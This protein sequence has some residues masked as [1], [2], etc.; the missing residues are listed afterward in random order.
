MASGELITHRRREGAV[1]LEV[2]GAARVADLGVEM[3]AA[4][5]EAIAQAE[6]ALGGI[7]VVHIAPL[8]DRLRVVVAHVTTSPRATFGGWDSP[9]IDPIERACRRASSI[10]MLSAFVMQS[11]VTRIT[12]MILT[13]LARG[14]HVRVLAGDYL[15]R[16]HPGALHALLD[17]A[18]SA[19]ADD[20]SASA[21][22]SGGSLEVR[23]MEM[24]SLGAIPSFHPKAWIIHGDKNSGEDAQAWVGSSNLSQAALTAGVE[25]NLRLSRHEDPEGFS[26]ITAQ[27]EALWGRAARVDRAWIMAYA[28][29]FEQNQ[30]IPPP[31]E[32]VTARP[33]PR[34]VQR[35]ALEALARHRTN[36]HD[37]ALVVLATGLGKTY[38]AAF[39]VEAFE[40]AMGR[41]ARILFVAHR[42]EL[43]RQ[44]ARTFRHIF[45]NRAVGFVTG[46]VQE[47][48]AQM[49]FASV[50]SLR[51][52]D[53]LEAIG[54]IDYLIIDEAHHARASTYMRLLEVVDTKFVLGLTATPERGD[55]QEILSLFGGEPVFEA[56]L[57]EGI[58]QG[59]LVPFEYFG[60][61]DTVDYAPIPWRSGKFSDEE[62][63]EAVAT[64][65][66][67]ERLL[68]AW[69]EHEGTRTLV[70]C[71][72]IGHADFVTAWL[73][74][75]G[76]RAA[77]VH[78][79][80]KSASR[81]HAIEQ[82][83]R[84]E[85]DALCTVD[86]F[87]EGVDIPALDR[88]VMLR[89]TGSRVIFL[90]QLGRG[91]RTAAGK[92]SLCVIDFVG[93]HTI[94]K[95]RLLLLTGWLRGTPTRL[96]ELED[97]AALSAT[98]PDGC[99]IDVELEAI[100]LLTHLVPN[101]AESALLSA[102]RRWRDAY[103]ARPTALDLEANGIN[104]YT[105][106]D[107]WGGWFQLVHEEGD[108]L[109]AQQEVLV[110]SSYW[111]EAL[112]AQGSRALPFLET[113]RRLIDALPED[114]DPVASLD[115]VDDEVIAEI[116]KR[117]S[118]LQIEARGLSFATVARGAR[119]VWK[120]MSLELLD[121]MIYRRRRLGHELSGGGSGFEAR[122]ISASGKAILTF[123][124][125]KVE[126]IPEGETPVAI[127]GEGLW[128]FRFV[129]MAVNVAAPHGS[130]SNQLDGLLRR[131]FGASAG[132][133]GTAFRVRFSRNESGWSAGPVS[134][135]SHLDED[136]RAAFEPGATLSG[137]EIASALGLGKDHITE[138]GELAVS[139]AWSVAFVAASDALARYDLLRGALETERAHV[140][141][142][143]EDG[144]GWVYHGVG[145][146][147]EDAGAWRIDDVDASTYARF[148]DKPSKSRTLPEY[149]KQ[150]AK[151][152][153]EALLA[154]VGEGGS[155]NAR[156]KTCRVVT[157]TESG[158]VHVDI[159]GTSKN[160]KVTNTDLAWVLLARASARTPLV[161]QDQVNRLRFLPGTAKG[162]MR[163]IDT[164]WALVLTEG[165]E[166]PDE[167]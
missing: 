84:G 116:T 108:L 132:Q 24:Q 139:D 103:D 86:L 124:R 146:R 70:F 160:R 32:P 100:D 67:M 36:G 47:F 6:R 57:G 30:A 158:T 40:Q 55:G 44:A 102:Y 106:K 109:H 77:A 115:S 38:L 66:R 21:Q 120:A 1:V 148:C 125:D 123:D 166:P 151:Q 41:R 25:W 80:E 130:D 117:I 82:L 143:R 76:I 33:S 52:T 162:S 39:D 91:L 16:T 42:M 11:G 13:A 56:R 9:L 43:L 7:C 54:E 48:D 81:E 92:T 98:L 34:A 78:S 23:V 107:I 111:F 114:G 141:F 37:R 79:G 49:I 14:A 129:K 157:V 60:I 73:D 22:T 87:N 127:A 51:R 26:S 64:Q 104:V 58:R 101:A 62:L 142:M 112:E 110:S 4:L 137:E 113:L 72:T 5:F 17:I 85:L 121:S 134:S 133:P 164:G 96:A 163:Y 10:D 145:A 140:F 97:P 12:P 46:S 63:A 74:E 35:E 167:T 90:Q 18:G 68:R 136:A 83:T 105:C 119:A 8:E 154:R 94:F 99:L 144:E 45:P 2:A 165:W 156:G 131:W 152:Y 128:V 155:I 88:V 28:T 15:T 29:R 161:D 159:G 3:R 65:A 20:E 89:P 126:G 59:V 138:P 53:R 69:E 135:D 147:A 122:V 150:W 61:K 95:E 149:A 50:Y 31:E 118:A 71:C 153:A 75:R 19:G 93:N 27:Y